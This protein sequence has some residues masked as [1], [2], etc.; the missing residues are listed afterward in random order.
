MNTRPEKLKDL[1]A[2][3]KLCIDRDAYRFTNHALE[4]KKRRAFILPDILYILKNGYHEK[5]KDKWDEQHH[6]WKYSIRGNTID[7]DEG[8]IIVTIEKSGMLIITVIRLK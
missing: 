2:R 5:V 6:M 8:R 4:R 3:I 7:K 1:M